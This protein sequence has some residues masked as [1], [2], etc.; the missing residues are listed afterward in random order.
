[1][2]ALYRPSLMPF[3]LLYIERKS[4]PSKVSTWSIPYRI[5]HRRTPSASSPTRTISS[6]SPSRSPG[7]TGRKP[8]NSARPW[9][10]RIRKPPRAEQEKCAKGR[11]THG[12]LTKQD[13]QN[14]K[15]CCLVVFDRYGFNNKD[16]ARYAQVTH[17]TAYFLARTSPPNDMFTFL[18]TAMG[19]MLEGRQGH[20]RGQAD[21]EN[22]RATGDLAAEPQQV[23]V[24][25]FSIE[26]LSQAEMASRAGAIRL[27]PRHGEECRRCWDRRDRCR[28]REATRRAASPSPAELCAAEDRKTLNKGWLESPIEGR[29]AR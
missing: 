24:R 5:D 17:Q 26:M 14:G 2:I 29:G 10:R 6:L 15:R 1:M 7:T 16:A 12:G 27:R 4:N 13:A 25:D 11:Q 21:G 9:A 3:I 19:D 23:L 28:A 22:R 20:G 8:I 18:S